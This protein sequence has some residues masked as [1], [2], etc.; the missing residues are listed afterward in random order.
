MLILSNFSKTQVL[1]GVS[2]K[3]HLMILNSLNT[4]GTTWGMLLLT[5]GNAHTV[6]FCSYLALS[7]LHA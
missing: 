6:T 2:I 4:A 3:T 7:A 5:D 1:Q